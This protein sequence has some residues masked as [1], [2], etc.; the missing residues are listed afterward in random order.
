MTDL[1]LKKELLKAANKYGLF[2]DIEH[3]D[4]KEG[5][6]FL[7]VKFPKLVYY[8]VFIKELLRYGKIIHE[9]LI[10]TDKAEIIITLYNNIL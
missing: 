10:S 3:F 2:I 6:L 8:N 1:F 5:K 4:N 7:F 9:K